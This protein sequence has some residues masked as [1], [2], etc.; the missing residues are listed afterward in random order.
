MPPA[1]SAKQTTTPEARQQ[2]EAYLASVPAD[3]RNALQKLRRAIKAAAPGAVEA[4]SY[5]MPA[6][7][8]D[9][10]V[11][12]CYRAA[13]D[14]CSLHPMSASVIRTQIFGGELLGV[15]LVEAFLQISRIHRYQKFNAGAPSGARDCRDWW[16]TREKTA[17]ATP[18]AAPSAIAGDKLS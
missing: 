16:R 6:F 2:V 9:G 11:L 1:A 8:L 13:K 12:A 18:P 4:I 10:R 15:N 7:K 17:S 5:G 14:H 3:A